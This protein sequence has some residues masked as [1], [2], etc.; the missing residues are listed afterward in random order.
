M[1]RKPVVIKISGSYVQPDNPGL[2]R[3]YANALLRLWSEKEVRPFVVVGGGR[4][5]RAYIEAGRAC[6]AGEAHLDVLGIM[7]TRLNATLLAV[8]LG[9]AAALP[10]PESLEEVM[11]LVNDPGERIVV[12]GG[13]QPGQSTNAV[14]VLVAE[15]AG[16]DVV[17]NASRVD[18]LYEKDPTLFPDARP[19]REA[20]IS[21]VKELLKSGRCYAGTYELFDPVS[22]AV[23]ERSR[24][25]LV[26]VKGD[27]P[28]NVVQ[29]VEGRA[30]GSI[31]RPD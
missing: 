23:A 29:A 16:S 18:S 6:G 21:E 7:V 5:A 25:T 10:V 30:Y 13:L 19:I 22:L 31:I 11:R 14:S 15:V 4:S 20:T 2:V 12:M 1:K 3:S 24:I 26:I 17:I 27:D 9:S 8:A 28:N